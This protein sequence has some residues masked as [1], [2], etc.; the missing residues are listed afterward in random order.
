MSLPLLKLF[1]CHEDAKIPTYAHPGD[2]GFDLHCLK[3]EYVVHDH[4]TIIATGLKP[5][6]PEGFEV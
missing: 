3:D 2:S 5:I 1:R 6:V 4:I